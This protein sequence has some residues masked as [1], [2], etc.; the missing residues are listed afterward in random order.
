VTR[1]LSEHGSASPLGAMQRWPLT[2][3]KI[4]DHAKTWH[5]DREVVARS[6]EGPVVRTTYAEIH[7]RAR[8]LSGA[9]ASL[10]VSE[11]DRV[12]TLAWNTARHI[13]AWYAT[14]GNRA[15]PPL[16]MQPHDFAPV[17]VARYGRVTFQTSRN[18]TASSSG[19]RGLEKPLIGAAGSG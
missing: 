16:P 3:D 4:L 14:M 8:R 6:V 9:L 7:R 1:E 15:I 17:V 5:G 18:R 2:V 12:A 13:E 11:G 19:A 10:G